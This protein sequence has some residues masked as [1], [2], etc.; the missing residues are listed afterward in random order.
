MTDP[1]AEQEFVLHLFAPLSGPDAELALHQVALL[2]EA[3]RT[4]LGMTRAIDGTSL[5]ANLPVDA[6]MPEGALAGLQD[7]AVNFQAIARREHDV[8]NVSLVMATPLAPPVRRNRVGAAVAPGWIEYSRWWRGL[9]AGGV[10]ALLGGA[11]IYQAKSAEPEQADVRAALPEQDDD[12]DRWWTR[13]TPVD[14][15]T[16]WEVTPGGDHALRR[17]VVLGRPDEDDRLSRFTWSSGDVLL[18]PLGRYLMHA[19][20]LRYAARVRGD[21]SQL[22]RVRYR[23]ATRMDRITELLIAGRSPADEADGLAAD[24]AAV[25]GTLQALNSM[26][27]SVDIAR[28]NMTSALAEPLPTDRALAPALTQWLADDV[29]FLEQVRIRAERTRQVLPSS[30]DPAP[31]RSAV[32]VRS[33]QP[34]PAQPVTMEQ[35]MCFGVDVVAFT[36][37]T[38]L[39][40]M[41]IRRR[42]AE[43]VRRVFDDI[44]LAMHDADHQDAGDGMTVVLP[45]RIEP[46][47]ALPKLLN[48]WRA[49]VAADNAAHPEDRIRLRLSVAAG[50][51]HAAAIGFTGDTVIETGRLLDSEA[52]RRAVTDHADADLAAL[53]SDRLHANV[54]AEGHSG[55]NTGHFTQLRVR[56]TSYDKLAW[57][58]VGGPVPP[59]PPK[60]PPDP[61]SPRHAPRDEPKRELFVIHG[62]AE[63]A[64]KA[65]FDFLRDIRLRPLEWDDLVART[66]S[67]APERGAVLR[68][69]FADHTASLVLFAPGP[70]GSPDV[71]AGMAVAL[72]PDRTILVRLGRAGLPDALSG[73]FAVHLDGASPVGLHQLAQLLRRLGYAVETDGTDWLDTNRF[74]DF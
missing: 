55:L 5:P 14:H 56:A 64:R 13:E 22:D 59:R 57:L 9:T 41:E 11:A 21:G 36:G 51:F 30:V 12:G 34:A 27:R 48:G 19:A 17:L 61:P 74:E 42:L 50:P 8:L 23:A 54:I 35:R 47:L 26:R 6:H 49:L 66:G 44:G 1:I 38:V 43:I 15:F 18:P 39:Q 58:W 28:E 46:H 68:Q 73:R 29:Y 3:C 60:R 20:K 53:I 10:S 52:L 33:A 69:A 16:V 70:G 7:P 24:E 37:R 25:I 63:R 31:P 72:Q 40:Q 71:L 32:V 62:D 45:A 4:Q 65:L 2:W 67:V